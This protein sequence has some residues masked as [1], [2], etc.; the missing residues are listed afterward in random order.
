MSP[1]ASPPVTL[2]VSQYA[3]QSAQLVLSGSHIRRQKPAESRPGTVPL[4]T[5]PGKSLSRIAL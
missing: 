4:H 2:G 3:Y 5:N 1:G